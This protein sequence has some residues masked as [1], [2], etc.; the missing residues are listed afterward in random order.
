MAPRLKRLGNGLMTCIAVAW[1]GY[2]A[3]YG[4]GPLRIASIL[5][6]L[7]G[8]VT[9]AGAVLDHLRPRSKRRRSLDERNPG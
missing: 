2:Q 7:V 9:A 1:F 3:L 4:D 5:F 6:L 8:V